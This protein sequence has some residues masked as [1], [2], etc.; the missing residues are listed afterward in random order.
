LLIV[1]LGIASACSAGSDQ[2]QTS[3]PETSA[4]QAN[5]PT[6]E[7]PQSDN[8][9]YLPVPSSQSP[10]GNLAE[11]PVAN[12]GPFGEPTRFAA[13]PESVRIDLAVVS[14]DLYISVGTPEEAYLTL[15]TLTDGAISFGESVRWST[16]G[17]D[18]VFGLGDSGAG[19]VELPDRTPQT[20]AVPFGDGWAWVGGGALVIGTPASFTQTPFDL[21]DD[22]L[23]ATD[24]EVVVALTEPVS[25]LNHGIV[26]DSIEGGGFAVVNL[27]GTVRSQ[28]S[29]DEPDVIEGRSA[30]LGDVTGDGQT[31]IVVT[32]SN[33][34]VGAWITVF[35]LDGNLIGQSD[36]IGLGSRWRHQLAITP[37]PNGP[38][39]LN[40]ITPH[41]GGRLQALR[42]MDGRLE[43]VAQRSEYSPHTINSRI[44]DGAYVGDLDG[45]GEWEV[46]LPDQPRSR[47]VA[48]S[49]SDGEFVEKFTLETP[50]ATRSESNI[51]VI[52]WNDRTVVATIGVD[53]FVSLWMAN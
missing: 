52:D 34:E 49:L 9:P 51:A 41:I 32:L 27:D 6:T 28:V 15:A 1:V 47:L 44:L 36:A 19:L 20:G 16:E 8:D 37:D 5:Q 30:M 12:G 33:A 11:H 26:G 4:P 35:D 24:G 46:L 2:G 14:G 50:Q 45:D 21:L 22:T 23:L 40:V 39:I 18:P 43:P 7:G 38:V 10:S 48:L 17:N 53:G 29:L 13:D 42:L 25:R 3:A 31:E